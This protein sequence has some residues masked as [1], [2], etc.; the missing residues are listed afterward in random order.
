MSSVLRNIIIILVMVVLLGAGYFLFAKRIGDKVSLLVQQP[1]NV[2]ISKLGSQDGFLNILL[3]IKTI[4]LQ[5]GSTL[6]SSAAFNQLRDISLEPVLSSPPG[7]I[8]PFAP[9]GFDVMEPTGSIAPI[10]DI[11]T[12]TL[13]YSPDS[14]ATSTISTSTD[15]IE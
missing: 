8:N 11:S 6:F 14:T 10:L 9:L 1:L 7:R 4:D 5:V 15:T 3:N 13:F 2:D 12:S